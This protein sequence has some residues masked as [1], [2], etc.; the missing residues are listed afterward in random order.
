MNYVAILALLA[1]LQA[2][3]SQDTSTDIP[4]CRVT[5][6][7]RPDAFYGDD[8]LSVA[9]PW[10]DGTVVF[11]PRGAGMVLPDGALSMKFGWN[12]G[13]VGRLAINGR[14]LDATAAPLRANIPDGYGDTGFQ[15]S[16]LIFPTPGCWEVTG[17]VG[18][19]ALTF[20]TRVI[21]IS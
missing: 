12:R 4:S 5:V 6:P 10:R 11:Q 18:E 9:L 1:T 13:V 20:V 2:G 19:A 15:A 14:R 16:A 21:K 8:K 17:K 7:D 3:T